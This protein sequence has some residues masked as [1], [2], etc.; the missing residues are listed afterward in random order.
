MEAGRAH[1]SR[2]TVSSL[3]LV[4]TLVERDLRLRAKRARLGMVWPLMAP[5]ISLILY[6]Y[7][8]GSVFHVPVRRYPVYLFCGLLPWTFLVQGI[9]S[10]LMTFTFNSDLVRRM[11]FPHELLPLSEVLVVGIYFALGLTGFVAYLALSGHLNYELLPLIVVPVACLVMLVMSLAMV[12][13][14]IDVYNRD[15]RA[16]IGNVLTVWFFLVP[17]VYRPD[18]TNGW[19]LG[20]RS[21]DPMNMLVG[22]FREVLYN[23]W[24]ALPTHWIWVTAVIFTIFLTCWS[25]FKRASAELPKNV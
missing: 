16:V 8:F 15:L 4:I 12:G 21:I 7:I 10:T 3:E 23:G 6:A 25:I 24:I 13:S 9:N 20:L 11:R 22:E 17:I 18:M 14:L 2:R 5:I 19:L 1:R